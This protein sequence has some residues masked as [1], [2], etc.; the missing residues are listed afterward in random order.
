MLSA[1]YDV[2]SCKIKFDQIRMKLVCKLS[3]TELNMLDVGI[4]MGNE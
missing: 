2:W 1:F 4:M 3:D